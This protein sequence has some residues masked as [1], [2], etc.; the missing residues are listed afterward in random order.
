MN[1]DNKI[2]ITLSEEDV[3]ECVAK[4]I[5]S[6]CGYQVKPENIS[7]NVSSKWVGYGLDERQVCYFKGCTAVVNGKTESLCKECTRKCSQFMCCM[8]EHKDTCICSTIE[9]PDDED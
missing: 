1:I 8:C 6:N 9:P 4:Y 7:F 3:K 5:S 2:T